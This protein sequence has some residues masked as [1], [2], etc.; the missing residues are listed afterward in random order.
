[1]KFTILGKRRLS[2]RKEQEDAGLTPAKFAV[3][4]ALSLAVIVNVANI[5]MG[6]H[7]SHK[8]QETNDTLSNVNEVK[9]KETPQVTKPYDPLE[10]EYHQ[11]SKLYTNP[12]VTPKAVDKK[13]QENADKARLKP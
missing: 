8:V 12:L 10:D 6:Q 3:L 7:V 13:L 9:N 1:M 11:Y 4:S 2:T 5:T